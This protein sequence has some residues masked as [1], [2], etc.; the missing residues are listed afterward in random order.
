MLQQNPG[1][2]EDGFSTEDFGIGDNPIEPL[3]VQVHI[4]YKLLT[5]WMEMGAN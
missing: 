1:S 3:A 4:L 5:Q 2:F